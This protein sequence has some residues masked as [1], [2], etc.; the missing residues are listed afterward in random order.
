MEAILRTSGKFEDIL[1]LSETTDSV[2][3]KNKI[4]EFC[5]KHKTSS[6]DDLVF[7]YSGHGLFDGDEFYYPLSDFEKDKIRQTSLQNTELDQLLKAV[8]PKLTVKIVDACNSGTLY[9]KKDETF[10][11]LIK[12]S[13][14]NFNKCYFMFSSQQDQ[15]SYQDKKLSYFTA[16]IIDAVLKHSG[17]SIRYKDLIDFISDAFASRTDQNPLFVTQADFTEIFC[18][19]SPELK[20]L[21]TDMKLESTVE[22]TTGK[23]QKPSSL[24]EIIA[25]QAAE[26]STEQEAHQSLNLLFDHIKS[27]VKDSEIF[28]NC[29]NLRLQAGLTYAMLPS[30]VLLVIGL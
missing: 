18:D 17:A 15:F 6:V 11:K 19:L 14:G 12:V 13:S 21:L 29:I 24:V 5:N 20:K 3:V 16:T 9:I 30:L 27:R 2:F 10:E 22:D 4:I 8:A 1:Y 7:Y 25:K 28:Q 23:E 26:Y